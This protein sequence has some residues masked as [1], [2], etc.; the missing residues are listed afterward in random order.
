MLVQT[1]LGVAIN[2]NLDGVIVVETPSEIDH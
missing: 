1:R 2:D